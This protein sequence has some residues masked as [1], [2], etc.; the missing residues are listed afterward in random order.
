V[1]DDKS[2]RYAIKFFVEKDFSDNQADK[3]V[4]EHDPN[5]FR[6]IVLEVI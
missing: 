4:K 6:K 2:I 5:N 1:P 3:F